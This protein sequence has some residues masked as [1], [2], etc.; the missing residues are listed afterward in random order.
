MRSAILLMALD[1]LPLRLEVA[2]QYGAHRVVDGIEADAP[3][4]A[5]ESSRG[6][7][8]DCGTLAFGGEGTAASQGWWRC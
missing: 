4:I 8:F 6:Y 5:R 1:R 2:R 3:A 7:G